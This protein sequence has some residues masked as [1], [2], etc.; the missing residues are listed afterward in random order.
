MIFYLVT[1]LILIFA[2]SLGLLIN[3]YLSISPFIWVFVLVPI[4]DLTYPMEEYRNAWEYLKE[5]CDKHGK[6]VI[7][8][9]L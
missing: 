7:E 4:I 5:P 9:G 3:P 6:I 8:T 2:S 1:P